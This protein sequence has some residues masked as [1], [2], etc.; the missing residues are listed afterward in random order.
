MLVEGRPS[1]H[2]KFVCTTVNLYKFARTLLRSTWGWEVESGRSSSAV[3]AVIASDQ[4]ASKKADL[5]L[6]L[7]M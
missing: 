2:M 6:S 5:T 1:P 4:R 3:G 7:I